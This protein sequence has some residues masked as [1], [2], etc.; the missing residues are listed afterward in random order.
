MLEH[1]T[2]EDIE[3]THTDVE[4]GAVRICAPHPTVEWPT[5]HFFDSSLEE[6]PDD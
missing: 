4:L 5:R 2:V 3:L 6:E 1:A